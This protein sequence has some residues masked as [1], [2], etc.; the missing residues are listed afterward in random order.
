MVSRVT[1]LAVA[2]EDA[3]S[4]WLCGDDVDQAAR[5][6]PWS[7]TV[8]HVIPRNRGG[9]TEVANLR[10]AHRRCNTQRGSRDPVLAW[11]DEWAVRETGDLFPMAL[12][13]ASTAGSAVVGFV[14]EAVARPAARWLVLR[15]TQMMRGCWEVRIDRSRQPA[16]VV[17][18]CVQPPDR[19]PRTRR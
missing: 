5:A 11:P 4:C 16:G 18:R 15:V 3:W 7:G 8:D 13:L 17:L 1:F 6:G 2:D 12:D 10:L 14:D 9:A 19:V